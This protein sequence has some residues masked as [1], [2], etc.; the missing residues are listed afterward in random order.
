MTEV[1]NKKGKPFSWSY[2][3][4]K[5]FETCPLKY[6][7]SRFFCDVPF[8]KTEASI[9]GDRVHKA[10]EIF[11]KVQPP[12]D[13]KEALAQVEP[14]VMKMF[15][16]GLHPE[17][18]LEIAL[19]RDLRL[20]SWFAKDC[21]FRI[22]IDVVLT[23][24]ARTKAKLFDWKTGGT[25]REDDDQLRLCA[26]ALSVIRPN[27]E[28]FTGKYIWT[29]HKKVTG[30]KPLSKAD[31]PAI[32]ADFLPRV[33]RMEDSWRTEIF[34]ARRSGLCGKYCDVTTCTHNGRGR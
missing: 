3:A 22:K 20:T 30:I 27:L 5:D 19:T 6:A 4:L 32:W 33:K 9:W 34:P 12:F 28:E 17:A 1:L 21:W 10:A 24:Y 26:A 18:E 16:S 14:Y 31:I 8:T 15:R 11:L 13:D 2:T 23:N 25:I 29:T 7:H